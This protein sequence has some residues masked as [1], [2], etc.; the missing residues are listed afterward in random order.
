M[1]GSVIR[2]N[3]CHFKTSLSRLLDRDLTLIPAIPQVKQ[4]QSKTTIKS[5]PHLLLRLQLHPQSRL[6]RSL[7]PRSSDCRWKWTKELPRAGSSPLTL[8][9]LE[10]K[11]QSGSLVMASPALSPWSSW[12]VAVDR[13]VSA[14]PSTKTG[15]VPLVIPCIHAN[16]LSQMENPNN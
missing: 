1:I 11:S 5:R 3:L 2:S 15:T 7:P 14:E 9:L 16:L 8:S 12:D 4:S 6:T 10:C 13:C